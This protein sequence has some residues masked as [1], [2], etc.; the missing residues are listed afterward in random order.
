MNIGRAFESKASRY[1]RKILQG[2]ASVPKVASQSFG[3]KYPDASGYVDKV[4]TKLEKKMIQGG[5]YG[6]QITR[7]VIG[8]LGGT[9]RRAK[10]KK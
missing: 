3:K 2:V 6:S 9:V 1:G 8:S 10:E 7:T 4:N 5:L